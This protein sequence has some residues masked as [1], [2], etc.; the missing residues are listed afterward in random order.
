M[1]AAYNTG[2]ARSRRAVS[3]LV[4][5]TQIH[6]PHVDILIHS[7]MAHIQQHDKEYMVR[8]INHRTRTRSKFKIFISGVTILL[9]L[10]VFLN[11]VAEKIPTTSDAVPLIGMLGI[12]GASCNKRPVSP[13]GLPVDTWRA[14]LHVT[15]QTFFFPFPTTI[16]A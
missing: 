13:A 12:L 16:S 7:D 5:E 11:L 6:H 8:S 1:G 14:P 4:Q 15:R 3:Y 9:S 2:Y 10:T